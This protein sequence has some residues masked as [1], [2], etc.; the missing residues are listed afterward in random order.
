MCVFKLVM[1]GSFRTHVILLYLQQPGAM[2]D[3]PITLL[4]AHPLAPH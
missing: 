4:S 2:Q 1:G 3:L